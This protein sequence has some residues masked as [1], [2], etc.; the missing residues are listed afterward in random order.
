MEIDLKTPSQLMS[1]LLLADRDVAKAVAET[2][3]HESGEPVLATVYF[4]GVEL[5]AEVMERVL[6]NFWDQVHR[7]YLEKY[8]DEEKAA[9]DKAVEIIEGQVGDLREK[10]DTLVTHLDDVSNAIKPYW[11]R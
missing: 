7:H 4:N 8:A 6:Q 2:E 9:H 11:E 3:R 1:H 5:P 10:V